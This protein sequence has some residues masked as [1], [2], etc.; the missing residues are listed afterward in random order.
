M[1]I[2][3]NQENRINRQRRENPRLFRDP[4]NN[5]FEG[6]V[7]NIILSIE[8]A[9][10]GFVQLVKNGFKLLIFLVIIYYGFKFFLLFLIWLQNRA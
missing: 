2:P 4:T 7:R 5:G 10:I 6:F 8:T 9:F 3:I 1:D